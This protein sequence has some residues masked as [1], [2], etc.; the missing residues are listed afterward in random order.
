MKKA[1]YLYR[2]HPHYGEFYPGK[3]LS[4]ISDPKIILRYCAKPDLL[5]KY[6]ANGVGPHGL[7]LLTSGGKGG[8][9]VSEQMTELTFELVRQMCYPNAP[10]RLSSLYAAET[11][12]GAMMWDCILRR[13][14]GNQY[15]QVPDSLWEIEFETEARSYDARWLDIPPHD[16]FSMLYQLEYA[17][18]YWK[19]LPTPNA[20]YELLVPYPVTVV[21]KIKDLPDAP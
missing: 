9:P 15:G 7:S 1:Y 8:P 4:V 2:P 13:N 6:M 5:N 19:E 20:L 16:G 11:I 18:N 21:R 14:F 3:V 12:G 10:S 17:H